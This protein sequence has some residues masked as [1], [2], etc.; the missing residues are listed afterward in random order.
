MDVQGIPQMDS[1]LVFVYPWFMCLLLVV[2]GMATKYSLEKRTNKEFIKDRAKRIL[3]PSIVGMFAYGWIC[4][5]VTNQFTD[6]FMGG[7]DELPGAVKYLIYCLMGTGP[8]WFCHVLFV[9]S[10]LIVLIRKLDKNNK[11]D[12]LGKKVKLWMILPLFFLILGS[13]FVLNA[14]MITV[15]RFGIYLLMFL[16]G[17]YI[18]SNEILQE[19]LEKYSAILMIV[20]CI[21]GVI[22]VVKY[23]GQNYADNGVLQNW[24]TN[25]YLWIAII[26]ILSF[27]KKYINF[28]NNFTKYM[29]KNNF[30]F[31]VLHYEVV[32]L[33]GFVAVR[34]MNLPFFLNYVIILIG[35]II[36]LPLLTE[37]I[38]RIP[39]VNKLILS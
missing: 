35:T 24:F 8:L 4:G 19:K 2:S 26:S 15:Y 33:L 28:N 16:L 34:Y 36:A 12:Q 18:F 29:T 3:V 32:L 11:L 7:G 31:Y 39:V 21:I 17:Y 1:F 38:K 13:S 30:S 14:P 37:I 25:L 9:A 23:Y 6:V 27:G 5:V 20:T 22:Y 10:L